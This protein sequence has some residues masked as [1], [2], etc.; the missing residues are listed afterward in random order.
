MKYLSLI[1]LMICFGWN[2]VVLAQDDFIMEHSKP[3][4][5]DRYED[6]KG[7]PFLFSDY[8]LGEITDL[9][10][11]TYEAMLNYNG[12]TGQ[13]EV[14]RGDSF[15]ILEEKYYRQVKFDRNGQ[16]MIFLR[17]LD[18]GKP[19]TFMQVLYKGK[20]IKLVNYFSCNLTERKVENVGKTIYFKR[21]N[22]ISNYYISELGE[23][24]LVK[25]S[26]GAL[27]K[28][29]GKKTM[30]YAKSEDIDI[31][32]EAGLVKLIA[33]YEENVME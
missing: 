13:F 11:K 26:K 14:K 4:E 28:L 19:N 12:Y 3:V 33:Y 27:T 6:A 15:I 20:K 29:L 10:G 21:F 31:K 32:S 24:T 23:M 22:P 18:R 7:S 25:I 5:V 8:I 16:E 2:D 1:T 9:E 30:N 17:G